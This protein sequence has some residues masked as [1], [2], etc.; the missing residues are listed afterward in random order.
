TVGDFNGDGIADLAV[1]SD[2]EDD[3]VKILLGHGDGTFTLTA[4]SGS[5]G[6]IYSIALGDFVGDGSPGLAA[7]N[8]SS[9]TVTVLLVANQMATTAATPVSLSPGDTHVVVANYGGDNNYSS[10]SSSGTVLSEGSL[11]TTLS[12]GLTAS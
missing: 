8:S 5:L 7:A 9:T 10:S 11:S 2:E 1:A 3:N 4:S 12:L 6:E